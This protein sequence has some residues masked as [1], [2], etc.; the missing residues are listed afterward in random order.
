MEYLKLY[1]NQQQNWQKNPENLFCNPNKRLR[2]FELTS[3]DTVFEKSSQ[4][5]HNS[6][7]LDLARVIIVPFRKLRVC[8]GL[9]GRVPSPHAFAAHA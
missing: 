1:Q 4:L 3:P 8:F 2:V 7:Y 6:S 9:C 5:T